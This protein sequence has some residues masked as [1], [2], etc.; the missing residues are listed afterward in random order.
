MASESRDQKDVLLAETKI[1]VAS[2][3]FR[4]GDGNLVVAYSAVTKQR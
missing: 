3:I 4:R 2:V 1:D